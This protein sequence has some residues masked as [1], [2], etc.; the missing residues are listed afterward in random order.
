MSEREL[1]NSA[2][3]FCESGARKPQRLRIPSEEATQW[4]GLKPPEKLERDVA[5]SHQL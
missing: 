4:G 2:R 5:T 1:G 3:N